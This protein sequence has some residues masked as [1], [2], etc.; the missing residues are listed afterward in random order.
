MFIEQQRARTRLPPGLMQRGQATEQSSPAHPAAQ[1]HV[2]LSWSDDTAQ[3][4]LP[5]A[6]PAPR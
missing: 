2:A 6:A 4:P 1:L 5:P 3:V